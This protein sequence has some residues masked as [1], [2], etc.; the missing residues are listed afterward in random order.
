MK[1]FDF[2]LKNKPSLDNIEIIDRIINN[3]VWHCSRISHIHVETEDDSKKL[4][5][6]I[7]D[8]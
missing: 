1:E 8:F 2:D 7:I 5:K 3:V 4:K 6:V